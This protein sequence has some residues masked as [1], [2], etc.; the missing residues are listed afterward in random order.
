MANGFNKFLGLIKLG[1]SD[2]DD[3]Y[4]DDDYDAEEE[5]EVVTKEPPKRFQPKRQPV[6][7]YDDEEEYVKPSKTSKSRFV[8]SNNNKV[9]P[10]KRAETSMEVCLIK[11]TNTE[12]GRLISDTLNSGKAIILNLE[13]IPTDIAQRIIDFTA[14]ACY[15]TGGNLQKVA[16]CIFICS[17]EAVELSGDFQDMISNNY[18]IN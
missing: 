16:Q 8:A 17:P 15:S 10:M 6:V 14:G 12:D 13:G 1:D 2:I 9:V 18:N 3:D 5:E 11:P 4:Y 7:E